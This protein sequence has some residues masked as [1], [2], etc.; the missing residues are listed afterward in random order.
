MG[1]PTIGGDLTGTI[2]EGDTSLTGDFDDVGLLTGND[3]DI[4]TV[5]ATGTYGTATINASTGQWTYTL[6]NSDPAVS[7][8]GPGETLTDIFTV[9]MLDTAGTGAGQ[10]DTADVTI[11]INGVVCFV[12]GTLI[13]TPDGPRPI[14]ALQA[15]DMVLTLDHGPQPI[16]WIGRRDIPRSERSANPKLHPVRIMAGHLGEGLPTRDLLVSRQHRILLCSRIAERMFGTPEVLIPAIKL[17]RLPGVFVDESVEEV[18][19]FH[20]LFDR[21]EVIFAEGAMAESLFAGPEA[22][23]VISAA[24]RTEI[25]SLL[26]EVAALDH[27]P[28]PSRAIPPEKLQKQLIDRHMRNDKSLVSRES[29][30]SL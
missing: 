26:P 17:S 10:S 15:G 30:I 5:T 3:D 27:A 12:A 20:L 14:E 24:A 2:D 21:H 9:N 11:T 28:V 1:T 23:K 7:G 6:D 16:R 18:A 13:E 25:L 4:F 22:L 19:Y 8:L 29:A